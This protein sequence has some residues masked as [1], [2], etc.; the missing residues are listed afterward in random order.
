[1]K[2]KFHYIIM[3]LAA[4]IMFL[5]GWTTYKPKQLN[6]A[7]A[8]LA[9]EYKSI[10]EMA[11]NTPLIAQ[12]EVLT[13]PSTFSYNKVLFSTNQVKVIRNFKG[14][15]KLSKITILDNGGVYKNIEYGIGG[16]PLMHIGEKYLLFLEKY[17]G[18]M[19]REDA[20][21]IK[22]VWQG[23]I[24]INSNDEFKYLGP[25]DENIELQRDIGKYQ[26]KSI[27]TQIN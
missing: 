8:S 17:V 19:M 25:S 23:K 9:N 27:Q 4:I 14:A 22:G 3:S 11:V 1:M 20:Y 2:K 18:P 26:L 6:E 12:V 7:P 13:N 21:V 10:K 16:T 5:V 24:K 15:E